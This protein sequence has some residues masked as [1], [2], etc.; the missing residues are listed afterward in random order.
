MCNEHSRRYCVCSIEYNI[1]LTQLYEYVIFSWNSVCSTHTVCFNMYW[2]HRTDDYGKVIIHIDFHY[3]FMKKKKS[4]EHKQRAIIFPISQTFSTWSWSVNNS[5]NLQ[6]SPAFSGICHH[7]AATIN[8]LQQIQAI[9]GD[10][11]KFLSMLSIIP[12]FSGNLWQILPETAAICQRLPAF[13]ICASICQRMAESA[14]EF[15]HLPAFAE[16]CRITVEI[17]II[18]I[19]LY[20]FHREVEIE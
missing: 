16:V 2:N 17:I 13:V 8:I 18:I 7:S 20:T 14:R 1:H 10:F 5:D 15:Q 4:T 3:F 9:S 19:I 12:A 6:H 11:R